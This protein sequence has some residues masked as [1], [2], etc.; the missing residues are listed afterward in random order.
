MR[1]PNAI[2]LEFAVVTIIVI[3]ALLSGIASWLMAG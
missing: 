1:R 2:E 3:A